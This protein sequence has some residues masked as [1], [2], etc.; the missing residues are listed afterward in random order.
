MS[1][2]TRRPSEFGAVE[3][4][5]SSHLENEVRRN[6]MPSRLRTSSMSSDAAGAAAGATQGDQ[7]WSGEPRAHSP[8]Q[9]RPASAALPLVPRPPPVPVP[10]SQHTDRGLVVLIA[11][12]NPISSKVL[13]TLLT[14]MGCRCV[15]VG[16]GS[17]AISVALGDIKFDCILMDYQMPSVDGEVAARYIKSTNNKNSTTPIVAVSAYNGYEGALAQGIFTSALSKP[18]SKND[19]LNTMKNLGFKTSQEGAK[20]K[21]SSAR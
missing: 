20:G 10:V 8:V 7:Q 18:L 15:V 17:E 6:S 5:K 12:D 21:L 2:H 19:L 1:G 3:R 11:E 13:E 14:R 16:D 4:F 9:S